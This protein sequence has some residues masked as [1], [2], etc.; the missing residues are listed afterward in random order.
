MCCQS[1]LFVLCSFRTLYC[2]GNLQFMLLKADHLVR[3]TME[4]LCAE[5]GK[6][7]EGK[8]RRG[9]MVR[10]METFP[11]AG[12]LCA[13]GH[14]VML[15]RYNVGSYSLHS[16]TQSQSD[17]FALHSLYNSHHVFL[18]SAGSILHHHQS[19]SMWT[20]Y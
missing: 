20:A 15:C 5:R 6:M 11:T 12:P 3:E 17:E 19:C 13:S 10:G 4:H 18:L 2:P 14:A 1:G 9:F 16:H 7:M 8:K